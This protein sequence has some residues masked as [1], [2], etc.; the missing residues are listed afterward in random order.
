MAARKKKP[1]KTNPPP[2][3][4][5]D[6]TGAFLRIPI[7]QET[8]GAVADIHAKASALADVF[9][10]TATLAA[11][12]LGSLEQVRRDIVRASRKRG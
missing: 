9:Q 10:T 8:V 1:K 11:G 2:A 6:A 4:V 12:L 5:V 3:A 7:P